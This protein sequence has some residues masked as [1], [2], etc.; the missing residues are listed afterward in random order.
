ME[1]EF[2]IEEGGIIIVATLV[3]VLMVIIFGVSTIIRF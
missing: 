2:V 1:Q 3:E